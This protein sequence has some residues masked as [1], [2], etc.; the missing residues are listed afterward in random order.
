MLTILQ[1]LFW[2]GLASVVT[3]GITKGA[4]KHG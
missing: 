2:V 1:I 4:R 3:Y